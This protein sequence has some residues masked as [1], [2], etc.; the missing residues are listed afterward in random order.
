MRLAKGFAAISLV[1]AS[2]AV[3]FEAPPVGTVAPF[4]AA[5][6]RGPSYTINASVPSDG[7]LRVFTFE[8]PYGRFE[9]PGVAAH[10]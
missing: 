7:F 4:L 8:T 6:A 1:I 5:A 3:A 9:V 10:S 2:P